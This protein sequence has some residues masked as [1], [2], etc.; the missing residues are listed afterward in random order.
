VLIL[1]QFAG[2]SK[3]LPEALI[4]NPYNSDQCAAAMQM[5]LEMPEAEQCSRMRHMRDLIKEFNVYRWAGKMLIDAAKLRNRV[6]FLDKFQ[7]T[8]KIGTA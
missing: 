6:R 1:S 8:E 4:V 7:S 3:E 2:A 5:A